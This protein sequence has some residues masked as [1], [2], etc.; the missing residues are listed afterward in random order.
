MSFDIKSILNK[1]K[2]GFGKLTGVQ[3]GIIGGVILL[4]IIL[5]VVIG[6]M[7]SQSGRY[8]LY[9]VKYKLKEKDLDKIVKSLKSM[10]VEF[11]VSDNQIF[12]ND[13]ETAMKMKTELGL[14]GIIPQDLKSWDLFDNQPFTT[15]DFERQINVRRAITVSIKEHIEMLDEIENADVVISYG[16]KEKYFADDIANNPLTASVVITPSPGSDIIGNKNKIKGLRDLIAKGVDQLKPENIVI[17]DYQGNVLTDKLVETDEEENIRLAKQHLQVKE[18]LRMEYTSDLRNQLAKVFTPDRL[19][20]KL[21]L[22][23]NWD[24]KKIKENLIKPVVIKEDNPE[25]PYDDSIVQDSVI[26]SKKNTTE[27]FKGQGYIPEGPGGIEDQIPAGLKEKMD[28]YN[29]YSKNEVI[30]NK[31]FS[32]AETEV[33]KDPYDLEKLTVTVFLDGKWEKEL[34]EDGDMIIANGR[35]KRKFVPISPETV[36]QVEES[37]KA[38]TGYNMTR[39]DKISVQAVSFDR[40][41]EFE[42]EDEEI[43]KSQRIKKTILAI[44]IGLVGIFVIS[45]IY[46]AIER[47]MARRRRIREEELIK[48]QEALRMAALKASEHD[49][50]TAELSPEERARLELQENALKVAKEKPEEVAKLIRTWLSSDE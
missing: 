37:L 29:T 8:P 36:K 48:Q 43:R 4:M 26:V 42:K 5:F 27:E 28:R 9:G 1:L 33:R 17:M 21:N 22:E 35:I 31:E 15:T 16:E 39:G 49:S 44:V 10:G 46:K 38:Y 40:S 2:T 45:I 47:E 7:S 32:R 18:K 12:V 19:D 23:L 24:V 3:K 6:G 25:T 20:L 14:E 30:E 34:D 41:S 13:K 50:I 11:E